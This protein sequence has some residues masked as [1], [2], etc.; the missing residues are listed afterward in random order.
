M[1]KGRER[2][3][4]SIL[5]DFEP[6]HFAFIPVL[7]LNKSK[8]AHE[9]VERLTAQIVFDTPYYTYLPDCACLRITVFKH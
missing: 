9:Q 3:H 7:G 5:L 4:R 6:T 8:A 2:E 1:T